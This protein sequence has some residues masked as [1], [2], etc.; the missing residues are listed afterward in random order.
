M[1][2]P[3]ELFTKVAIKPSD[4]RINPND[5]GLAIGSCFA[6]RIGSKLQAGGLQTLVNPFGT[7]FNPV[8]LARLLTDAATYTID[9]SLLVSDADGVWYHHHYHRSV[10]AMSKAAL[11]ELIG[12]TQ[13]RLRVYLQEIDFLIVTLGTAYIYELDRVVI[14][15]CHKLPAAQF[16]RRLLTLQE[17]TAALAQMQKIVP[18]SCNQ[19]WTVS[20]VRHTRD[21]LVE[22][23]W[24][25][26]SMILGLQQSLEP[27]SY[28]FPA[29]EMMIDELRDYRYYHADM[30]HPNDTAVDY[31]Y[32]QFATA[33]LSEATVRMITEVQKLYQAKQHKPF[34]TD[35]Q[36]HQN[37]LKQMLQKT[38]ALKEEY[39]H[40]D[41][42]TY[43]EY[44]DGNK[45]K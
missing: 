6:D 25:K 19:I 21:G 10:R 24:S 27:S 38:K 39:P 32:H 26:A 31:I 40:L 45:V 14:S 3:L 28:Y 23:Q 18:K 13:E 35:S 20:P 36:S 7:V 16:K 34:V 33:T 37:F 29:Y 12:H 17:I 30:I 11:I 22:N 2:S 8:S 5:K 4:F 41:I 42:A 9:E 15:N 44:F 1:H 43:E